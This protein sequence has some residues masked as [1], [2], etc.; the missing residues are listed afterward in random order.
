DQDLDDSAP[1]TDT[2]A[3]NYTWTFTVVGA[4]QP[5]P[6]APSVHLTMGNPTGAVADVTSYD[7]FLLEKPTY[8]LSY[9]RSKG[10]PNWVSWHLESAWYGSLGRVDTFRPDPAIP[11]TWY[12]VQAS[13]FFTTGF[14]RGHMCPNAD[15]DNENRIPINQETY[16][17]TNMV[18]QAPDNN[19]GPWANLE[20][21]LRTLTDAGSEIYIVSGPSGV[22]GTG[23]N[24]GVTMTLAGGHVTVPAYTWKAALVLPKGDNDLSRITAATRTIAVV[25]PNTQGIRTTNSNDW[26]GY[27]TTVDDIELHYCH[28]NLFSNVGEA[29]QNAIEAGTNGVNPPGAGDESVST[30]EDTAKSFT[31][32]VASPNSN[33]LTY[34]IVS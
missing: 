31:L 12:R 15:R 1:N 7:N 30:N 13:D 8:A 19:Q 28:C 6:Y 33:T 4:G 23:S 14:D 25:M 5:A 22:G 2:L 9:N 11:P 24:G 3:A 21:Y 32:D 29:I 16:L 26:Q 34:T 27:L 17:M 10:T 20:N 18:P